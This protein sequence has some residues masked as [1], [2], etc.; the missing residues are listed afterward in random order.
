L[1]LKPTGTTSLP[2]AYTEIRPGLAVGIFVA[3]SR[4]IE[5][6]VGRWDVRVRI[7]VCVTASVDSVVGTGR[8]CGPRCRCSRCTGS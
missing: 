1:A 6:R 7:I 2:F 8:V 5:E 4:A 3:G